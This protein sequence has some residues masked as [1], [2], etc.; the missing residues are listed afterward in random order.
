VIKKPQTNKSTCM[1][2]MTDG[3]VFVKTRR[4]CMFFAVTYKNVLHNI[5]DPRFCLSTIS[6][7]IR[8]VCCGLRSL[9]GWVSESGS[10]ALALTHW[11]ALAREVKQAARY[12]PI[13]LTEV[14]QIFVQMCPAACAPDN[15]GQL[16]QNVSGS[17]YARQLRTKLSKCVWQHVLPDS[18]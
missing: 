10:A 16:C 2:S 7:N 6:T 13:P 17:M 3:H 9:S 14:A 18:F 1:S 15:C 5:Y 11:A 8:F 4:Q 12:R